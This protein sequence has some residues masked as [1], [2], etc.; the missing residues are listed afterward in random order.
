M[1]A[2]AVAA[3]AAAAADAAVAA[4]APGSVAGVYRGFVGLRCAG[5]MRVG[6]CTPRES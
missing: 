4:Y 3:A 2:A 5:C 6:T 1:D